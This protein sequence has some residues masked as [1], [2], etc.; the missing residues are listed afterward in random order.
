[1]DRAHTERFEVLTSSTGA[2]SIPIWLACATVQEHYTR[3]TVEKDCLTTYAS[4]SRT[5]SFNY[6]KPRD[7]SSPDVVREKACAT[8]L[9]VY[10][11]A[12]ILASFVVQCGHILLRP[13]PGMS[14]PPSGAKALDG[15]STRVGAP[16]SP[17]PS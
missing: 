3:T 6:G 8:G 12:H 15:E 9:R 11:G 13:Q 5:S 7:H 14:V 17:P 4:V 2:C 1:M 10:E 16:P